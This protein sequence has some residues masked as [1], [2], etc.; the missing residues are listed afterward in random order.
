MKKMTATLTENETTKHSLDETGI[1]KVKHCM[2]NAS[3]VQIHRKIC[4]LIKSTTTTIA[5][6]ALE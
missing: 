5:P 1:Q 4:T 3:D 2:L 6:A